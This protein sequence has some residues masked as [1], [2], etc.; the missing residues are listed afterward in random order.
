LGANGKNFR[1]DSIAS[2]SN[3]VGK[4]HVTSWP[5]DFNSCPMARKGSISPR[6]PKETNKMFIY[7]KVSL[8]VKMKIK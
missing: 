4:A 2:D 8:G 6:V 7:E 3:Y 1:P 5:L